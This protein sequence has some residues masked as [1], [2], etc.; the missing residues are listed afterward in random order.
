MQKIDKFANAAK[1][2]ALCLPPV[3][4]SLVGLAALS[5]K[6]G[7]VVVPTGKRP[8]PPTMPDLREARHQRR[9]TV[10]LPLQRRRAE[11]S[12]RSAASLNRQTRCTCR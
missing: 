6:R 5:R 9:R 8:A 10:P 3:A 2:V 7:G 4:M 1:V 12:P 11:Q